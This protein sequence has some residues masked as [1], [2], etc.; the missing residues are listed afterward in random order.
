VIVNPRYATQVREHAPETAKAAF[1]DEISGLRY[2]S[3]STGRWLNRDPLGEE[4]GPNP[5]V[6][7]DND[8][9]DSVDFLGLKQ[10]IFDVFWDKTYGGKPDLDKLQK[11]IQALKDAIRACQALQAQK[12]NN[13]CL[14]CP[15]S[16]KWDMNITISSNNLGS[17]WLIAPEGQNGLFTSMDYDYSTKASRLEILKELQTINKTGHSLVVYTKAYIKTG[18]P[19]NP[20][21]QAVTPEGYG[22][23]ITDSANPRT[24]A[25]ETGHLAGYRVAP[26]DQ[27]ANILHHKDPSYLMYFADDSTGSKVDCN[28][29][30]ALSSYAK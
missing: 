30:K 3:P 7:L 16:D 24:F 10:I 13:G 15:G 2:Y 23:I 28:Y 17:N 18:I 6:F 12:N 1:C 25:H 9:T 27:G 8:P 5:F 20:E 19:K 29:C 26:E 11:G 4:A 14:V 21:A 22:M